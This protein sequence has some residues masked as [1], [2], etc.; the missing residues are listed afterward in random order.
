MIAATGQ[1]ILLIAVAHALGWLA[2][3]LRQPALIGHMTAGVLLGPSVL[4]YI[5]PSPVLVSASDVALFFVVLAAGLE[6]RIRDVSELLR[7]GGIFVLLLGLFVPAAAA[8][9][10]VW[11]LQLP[12]V[13]ALVIV[14]CISVT[15]LPVALQILRAFNLLDTPMAKLAIVSAVLSDI[16][17]LMGLSILMEMSRQA[18]GAPLAVAGRA[19]LELAALIALVLIAHFV[20]E[21]IA[22]RHSAKLN[23]TSRHVHSMW[24]GVLAAF[25]SAGLGLASARLGLHFAIGA[26]FGAMMITR[27]LMGDPHFERFE[28]IVGF[29]TTALFAPLFLAYQGV[30]FDLQTLS[31]YGFLAAILSV[32]IVSKL[33]AGYVVGR[34]SRMSVHTSI[35]VGIVMNARGVMEMVV[36][37][38]AYR[39]GLV[40]GAMFSALLLIGIV[41]SML[42]P[43]L[44]ARWQAAGLRHGVAATHLS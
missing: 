36:A 32:A 15:A 43:L 6:L 1:V 27:D 12:L 20:C 34:M 18:G 17:V 42:T 7:G 29:V 25:L 35:G 11:A 30:K 23:D 5:S 37:S 28:R 39:A 24:T 9:G 10:L 22:K 16:I 41:T 19:L 40:D 44:L 38:I 8:S 33:I 31:N 14:L 3:Q 2:R 13:S 4:S 21:Y 26:F